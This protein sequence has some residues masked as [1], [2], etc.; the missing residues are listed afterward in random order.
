MRFKYE[1]VFR[2]NKF[3]IKQ[4]SSENKVQINDKIQTEKKTKLE[5]DATA[6]RSLGAHL[7]LFGP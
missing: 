4:K 7:H 3:Q 5:A 1:Q 2:K 6:A